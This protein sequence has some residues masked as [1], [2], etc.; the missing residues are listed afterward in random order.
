MASQSGEEM[1]L[2][3][4]DGKPRLLENSAIRRNR[5]FDDIASANTR[6]VNEFLDTCYSRPTRGAD[7]LITSRPIAIKAINQSVPDVR[8]TG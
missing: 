5:L 2:L 4:N 3:P 6:S 7:M 1:N 8:V